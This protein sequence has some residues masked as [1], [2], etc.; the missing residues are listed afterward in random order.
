MLAFE[1]EP[2]V[3]PEMEIQGAGCVGLG[4]DEGPCDVWWAD[5]R[6]G[7]VRALCIYPCCLPAP[8]KLLSTISGASED[9]ALPSGFSSVMT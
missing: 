4:G 6:Q 1:S 3:L 2:V 7:A 8:E 5:A 9:P